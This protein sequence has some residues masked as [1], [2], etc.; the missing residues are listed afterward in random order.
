[1]QTLDDDLLWWQTNPHAVAY[2]E[3]DEQCDCLL[4][5]VP[6]GRD[7]WLERI[8]FAPGTMGIS[9]RVGLTRL[10]MACF[11]GVAWHAKP[12]DRFDD[13]LNHYYLIHAPAA[14]AA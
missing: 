8:P 12:G 11:L 9:G 7:L 4:V 14:G 2:V 10:G 6:L 5:A 3:P 1:M 13:L